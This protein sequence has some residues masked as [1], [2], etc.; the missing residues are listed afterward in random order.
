MM[1]S[2]LLLVS[3][4][5]PHTKGLPCASQPP[6]HRSLRNPTGFAAGSWYSWPTGKHSDASHKLNGAE[7]IK[8]KVWISAHEPVA[9]IDGS[10]E[11]FCRARARPRGQPPSLRALCPDALRRLGGATR[12]PTASSAA[13]GPRTGSGTLECLRPAVRRAAQ[14]A[15]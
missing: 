7:I 4:I 15:A 11:G 13:P 3:C 10:R 12:A 6:P 1:K 9:F 8:V 5:E 2:C 14:R